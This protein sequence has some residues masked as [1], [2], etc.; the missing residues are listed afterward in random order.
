MA[1]RSRKFRRAFKKAYRK[2]KS[3]RYGKG[4][5]PGGLRLVRGA[6]RTQGSYA[7][8]QARAEL[9]FC[10]SLLHNAVYTGANQSGNFDFAVQNKNVD[11]G[12][13]SNINLGAN[14]SSG[15]VFTSYNAAN[16]GGSNYATRQGSPGIIL[17]NIT[18]GSDA[19][20]R[21][22]RKIQIK[23]FRVQISATLSDIQ[24][25]A[26]QQN[27][28]V[29]PG[30]TGTNDPQGQAQTARVVIV[31]DKQSNGM[32]AMSSDVFV[33]MNGTTDSASH[34]QL[35]NRDRFVILA[36]ER[37]TIGSN[38]N[39]VVSFDIYKECDLT[40]IYTPMA[41]PNPQTIAA[42][43]SGT[44]YAFFL[45]DTAPIPLAAITPLHV[46]STHAQCRIR[47]LDA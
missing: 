34:M 19:T 27:A 47:Y 11:A 36:D 7:V 24:D 13:P 23:S 28:A 15:L 42:I 45:G 22:G 26:L 8:G 25:V 41:N 5:V 17:N 12:S 16:P 3:R 29:P 39:S 40:T 14:L 21:I 9:K 32:Q 2:A 35:N 43:A 44:L 4:R 33:N 6:L 30:T 1:F 31:W 37:K 46:T 18:Q 10:D 20:Q 38:G